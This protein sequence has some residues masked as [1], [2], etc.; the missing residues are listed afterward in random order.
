MKDL[1]LKKGYVSVTV[2]VDSASLSWNLLDLLDVVM[3]YYH[4]MNLNRKLYMQSKFC[5]SFPSDRVGAGRL[6]VA[7][8]SLAC[9][10]VIGR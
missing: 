8:E 9:S 4:S 3:Y 6:A 5:N 2:T 7:S 1:E 10:A